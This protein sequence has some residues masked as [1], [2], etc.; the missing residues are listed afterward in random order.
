MSRTI[1]IARIS[2]KQLCRE[3]LF[4]LAGTAFFFLL[5]ATLGLPGETP[6]SSGASVRA[7]NH[8]PFRVNSPRHQ[9]PSGLQSRMSRVDALEADSHEFVAVFGE[10]P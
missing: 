10:Q 7:D 4:V 3:T 5:A 8:V 6:S 9:A 2:V 1:G